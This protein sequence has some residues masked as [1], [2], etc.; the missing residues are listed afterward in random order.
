MIILPNINLVQTLVASEKIREII[1]SELNITISLGAANNIIGNPIDYDKIIENAS[2][3]L[4]EAKKM[5]IIL[6]FIES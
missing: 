5:E 3:M 2:K 1:Q 4:N 6:K